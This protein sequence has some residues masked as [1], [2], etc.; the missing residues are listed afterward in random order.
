M[1]IITSDPKVKKMLE[2]GRKQRSDAFFRMFSW[3][4]SAARSKAVT[5]LE[6]GATCAQGCPS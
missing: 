6:K 4:S 3:F 2:E 5:T 1:L